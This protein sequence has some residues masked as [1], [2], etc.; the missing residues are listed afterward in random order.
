MLSLFR[1]EEAKMENLLLLMMVLYE[2]GDPNLFSVFFQKFD[3]EPEHSYTI[4][5]PS[6]TLEAYLYGYS[7]A[8]SHPTAS[9]IIDLGQMNRQL[10][11]TF[12]KGLEHS[13]VQCS[14]KKLAIKFDLACTYRTK[15][16]DLALKLV[17]ISR[18]LYI[19]HC[20]LDFNISEV[21][22]LIKRGECLEEVRFTDNNSDLQFNIVSTAMHPCGSASNNK[23]LSKFYE[24]VD[25]SAFTF[26]LIAKK[27]ETVEGV[28]STFVESTLYFK[29][30]INSL[31]IYIG[32]GYFPTQSFLPP[33]NEFE[34]IL[35][36]GHRS[37]FDNS[38]QEELFCRNLKNVFLVGFYWPNLVEG[39]I[40]SL[41]TLILAH[42]VL[43][44]VD[45][46]SLSKFLQDTCTLQ[47]LYIS[48]EN[49]GVDDLLPIF[50]G[51]SKCVSLCSFS[52]TAINLHEDG[53]IFLSE[54]L[55]TNRDHL[56]DIT[57]IDSTITEFGANNLVEIL[58]CK[59]Q[60]I[61]TMHWK[62]KDMLDD[63]KTRYNEQL[64]FI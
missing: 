3:D 19:I 2:A 36:I 60:V 39:N 9:W 64:H 44:D 38:S 35:L 33:N 59:D 20:C 42:F 32:N 25:K 6:N 40:R 62:Y 27:V 43:T 17:T 5:S 18:S 12:I 30:L 41:T 48:C 61:L 29:K 7:I 16:F 47:T 58:D 46:I 13:P 52:Y 53:A 63:W 4:R 55:K 24:L 37:L 14:V 11:S 8:H 22:E 28:L 54:Q 26:T 50:F 45:A 56:V 49:K 34:T 31:I 23:V 57:I 51:L 21:H 10:A 15:V 1:Q